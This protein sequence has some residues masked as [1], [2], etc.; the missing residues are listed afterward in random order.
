MR[1]MK[2]MILAVACAVAVSSMATAEPTNVS[3][4][5]DADGVAIKGYDPVAYFT[6]NR[7]ERGLPQIWSEY[8]GV[9]FHF[10][11]PD[12][13]AL[14]DAEPERYV[15]AYGGWCAWAASRNSLADIDPAAFTIHDGRLFL[16]YSFLLNTRFRVGLERNIELADGYWP[17]LAEQ[18]S[19]RRR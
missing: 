16:N 1:S 5:V 12:H 14:F 19:A 6:L 10:A 15:P 3:F 9:R 2:R 18:A 11:D 7:A 8:E 17:T 13:K 4:N